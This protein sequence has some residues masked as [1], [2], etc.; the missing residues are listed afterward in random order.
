MFHKIVI[1]LT[2]ILGTIASA[3]AK[4]MCEEVASVRNG[5]TIYSC[6]VGAAPQENEARDLARE[7]AF[8]EFY[9]LC[10]NSTDCRG[11]AI[12]SK[13]LRND[14]QMKGN[15][16]NC[17]RG[18]EI[19]ILPVL[20]TQLTAEE[21]KRHLVSLEEK[22][23]ETS[24]ALDQ[25]NDLLNKEN[26]LK[27]LQA[28]LDNSLTEEERQKRI[29]DLEIKIKESQ[30][31]LEKR[32][33]FETQERLKKNEFDT[34]KDPQSTLSHTKNVFWIGG[35]AIAFND[36]PVNPGVASLSLSYERRWKYLGLKTSILGGLYK[37]DIKKG[38]DI[39]D[40]KYQS[41]AN[42]NSV[43]YT[44]A[45]S[46]EDEATGSK[47]GI[48]VAKLTIPFYFLKYFWIG[49]EYIIYHSSITK[50]T[51]THYI[52]DDEAKVFTR[53][54]GSQTSTNKIY[55]GPSLNLGGYYTLESKQLSFF[56]STSLYKSPLNSLACEIISGVA[57]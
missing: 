36:K 49:P 6:G 17:Y 14:C 50:T 44:Q 40:P 43:G 41:Y 46:N 42:Y 26:K 2:I 4:W 22:T 57:F 54:S 3:Q 12:N 51:N 34:I 15:Q 25:Q 53:K 32:K 38:Q 10:N 13:P 20:E 27:K 29:D 1:L 24:R 48:Q 5:D 19:T 11:H 35:G 39:S 28:E 16:Y 23:K 7:N 9:A 8:K 33:D 56:L 30:I 21:Y 52:I 45:Y 55:H 31:E 18:L 37:H 47:Y